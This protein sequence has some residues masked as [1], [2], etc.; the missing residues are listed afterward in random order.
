MRHQKTA[1]D[2]VRGENLNSL[3]VFDG[4]QKLRMI[5]DA[6]GMAKAIGDG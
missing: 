5:V 4:N 6:C 3:N 2:L 1:V